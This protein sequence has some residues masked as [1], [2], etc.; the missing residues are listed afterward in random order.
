MLSLLW[1][2]TSFTIEGIPL[3]IHGEKIEKV[4]TNEELGAT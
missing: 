4:C 3:F 1:R 2:V